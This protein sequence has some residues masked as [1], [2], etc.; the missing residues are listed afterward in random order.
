[1]A[2]EAR[3]KEFLGKGLAE[4]L[5]N[6][7][8]EKNRNQFVKMFREQAAQSGIAFFQ[9]ASEVPINSSD[10]CYPEYQEAFF[11][12]LFGV[13]EMD[14]FGTIDF[15][16]GKTTVFVPKMDNFYKIW[17]TTLNL[18]E[19]AKKYPLIDEFRYTDDIEDYFKALQPAQVYLNSGVNSCSKLTS[20]SPN[21]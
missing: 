5:P 12:Y 10:V 1:M 18:E 11:Y 8:F 17:M 14:S 2:S 3:Q 6:T 9:G 15:E 19:Y 16:S 20:L 21:I 7:L 13:T 4:R